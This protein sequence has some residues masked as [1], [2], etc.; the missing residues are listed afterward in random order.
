MEVSDETIRELI[1]LARA[2][3]EKEHKHTRE[4]VEVDDKELLAPESELDKMTDEELLYYATPFY[5]EL[6]AKKEA[7]ANQRKEDE[8]RQ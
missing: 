2:V 5:D 4:I 3:I 8:A 1:A 6:Q 7:M